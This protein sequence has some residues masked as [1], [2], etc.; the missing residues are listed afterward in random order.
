MI[1]PPILFNFHFH[2]N[3]I[4]QFFIHTQLVDRLPH[5]IEFIFN[6][7]SHHRVH[8]G[9]NKQYLDKNYGGTL[10]I[11]DRIFGT[12]EQEQEKVVYGLTSNI[13]SWSVGW[14]NLHYWVEMWNISQGLKGLHK[15]R[16][17]WQHPGWAPQT[18]PKKTSTTREKYKT[19]LSKTK[20]AYVLVNFVLAYSAFKNTFR[21]ESYLGDSE[22]VALSLFVVSTLVGIGGV[23]DSRPWIVPYETIRY[24]TVF[25][26]A[27]S[28]L[29]IGPT[30][31]ENGVLGVVCSVVLSADLVYSSLSGRVLSHFNPIRVDQNKKKRA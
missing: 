25:F 7:P 20:I 2:F 11:F 9:S 6:T 22:S 30:V 8:H 14:A 26:A 15:L 5:P 12:F 4:Y 17:L 21:F 31:R 1:F 19:L 23:M 24:L 3:R 10:I 13:D 27:I 29:M 18:T 16:V 28:L